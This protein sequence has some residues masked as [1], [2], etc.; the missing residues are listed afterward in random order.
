MSLCAVCAMFDDGAQSRRIGVRVLPEVFS[1][2]VMDPPNPLGSSK[3]M[4]ALV[5]ASP[6]VVA[7]ALFFART[8]ATT[9][10]TA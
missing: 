10:A 2:P 9:M 5:A 4:L 6:I 1:S 8:K 7:M 3:H